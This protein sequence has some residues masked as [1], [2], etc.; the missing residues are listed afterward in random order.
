MAHRFQ[1]NAVFRANR[2]REGLY[3]FQK[4]RRGAFRKSGVFLHGEQG[5]QLFHHGFQPMELGIHAGKQ[6]LLLLL[7][8]I[9]RFQCI[10]IQKQRRQGRFQLVGHSPDKELL[11]LVLL[12]QGV[13]VGLHRRGHAVKISGQPAHLVRGSDTDPLAVAAAGNAL[14]RLGQLRKRTKRPG[15]NEPDSPQAQQPDGQGQQRE[16]PAELP[17]LGID[18][19]CVLH[20]VYP[21]RFFPDVQGLAQNQEM[22]SLNTGPGRCGRPIGNVQVFLRRNGRGSV[23]AFPIYE[24][25]TPGNTAAAE[26]IGQKNFQG[27]PTLRMIPVGGLLKFGSKLR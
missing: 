22:L 6:R 21:A 15:D 4:L 11:P 17:E 20:Q 9:D 19:V 5:Q 1:R 27:G 12:P 10:H 13:H 2:P 3:P 16:P 23:Q 14:R 8:Q 7:R 25:G 18:M 24:Q 26:I